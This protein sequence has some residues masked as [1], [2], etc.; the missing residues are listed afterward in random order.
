MPDSAQQ[1]SATEPIVQ[2]VLFA[3]TVNFVQYIQH[4]HLLTTQERTFGI[5][6][7]SQGFVN[8][9]WYHPCS[10]VILWFKGTI[11]RAIYKTNT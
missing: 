9:F 6:F 8:V 3:D 1:S 11:K 5:V 4:S 10:F 2:S 7:L